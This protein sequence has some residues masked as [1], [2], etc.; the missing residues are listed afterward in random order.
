MKLTVKNFGPIKSA[1]V[2]VKPLTVFVGPS[3][4]GKSYLAMLIYITAK[5]LKSLDKRLVLHVLIKSL[6]NRNS[7]QELIIENEKLIGVRKAFAEC[8]GFIRKQWA[9]EGIRCFGEEWRNIIK[10]NGASASVVISSDNDKI[11]LDLL[12]RGKDKSRFSDAMVAKVK[13]KI[14][15]ELKEDEDATRLFDETDLASFIQY[16]MLKLINFLPD[17]SEFDNSPYVSRRQANEYANPHYLPAVRG[18]LMQ[19]HR[20]LV[21]TLIDRA[22]VIGLTGAAEIVP[23]TGVLADFLRKLL[24]ISGEHSEL[25]SSRQR[26]RHPVETLSD[27]SEKI[28]REVMHGEITIKKL[29]TRYPDFRYRFVDKNSRKRDISLMHASSSVSEL[30]PLVLFIRYYLSP[31]DIFIVEEP[32]AHLHPGAQRKVAGILVELVNAGVNVVITTHSDVILEQISNLIHADKVPKAKVFGQAAK[33]RTLSQEKAGCY[34]FKSLTVR[35]ERTN[36]ESVA[37]DEQTGFLTDD[38]LDVSSKLYN[39]TVELL[40][41]KVGDE[42]DRA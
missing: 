35:G 1:Q 8:L 37:F 15:S 10:Q 3:N 17:I 13:D 23:F 28:E 6:K 20:I 7:T 16:E 19:S 40:N 14:L 25:R 27:L 24:M 18:G 12:S 32:E 5:A 11:V 4:T 39:E 9:D 38:H 26:S 21:G 36:V 34:T 31:N 41:L 29:V 2:D 22:P 30:T 33:G 42:N